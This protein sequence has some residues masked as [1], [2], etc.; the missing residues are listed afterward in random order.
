MT[1]PGRVRLVVHAPMPTTGLEPTV[2]AARQLASRCGRPSDR[3]ASV[4]KRLAI[5]GRDPLTSTGRSDA[6]DRPLARCLADSALTTDPLTTAMHIVAIIA[7]G[8]RGQRL[9]A[10][11][12]KQLLLLG[13][14]TILAAGRRGVR[15]HAG[16]STKSWWQR[17]P[18]SSSR[19]AG[20]PQDAGETAGD[21]GRRRAAAGFGGDRVRR[22]QRPRR[23]RSGARCRAPVRQ[24]RPDRQDHR[25]RA[26]IGRGDPGGRRRATRSR[27]WPAPHR[28]PAT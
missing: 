13:G 28:R 23:L 5:E 2:G 1:C 20:V 16:A 25:R 12:P 3:G 14:R 24:L 19:S 10:G 26:R 17:H 22:D 8:G 18:T 9:G 6:D 27:R 4:A 11:R 21:R 15:R 7:A